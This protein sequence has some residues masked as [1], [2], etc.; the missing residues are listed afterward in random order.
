M[1]EEFLTDYS[2]LIFY[3]RFSGASQSR[4]AGVVWLDFLC[5]TMVLHTKNSYSVDLDGIFSPLFRIRVCN[6]KSSIY[7]SFLFKKTYNTTKRCTKHRRD[8]IF[9]STSNLLYTRAFTIFI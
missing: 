2:G 7:Q 8:L 3:N 5:K 9:L 6:A 4:L 1:P